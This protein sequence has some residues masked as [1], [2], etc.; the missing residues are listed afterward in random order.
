MMALPGFRCGTPPWPCRNSRRGWSSASGRNARRLSSSMSLA[1]SWNAAL[2]T[3]MSSP[4]SVWIVCSTAAGAKAG[5]ATSPLISMARRPSLL[6]RVL[7]LL[8]VLVGVEVG[9]GDVGAF[10]GEQ[11]RHGPAD[12]G[13]GAGDQ[14]R[15]AGELLGALVIGRVVHRRRRHHR[16]DAGLFLVLGGE[17]RLRIAPRAGLHGAGLAGGLERALLLGA[18]DLALDR[19][20][21]VDGARRRPGLVVRS[22]RRPCHR[23]LQRVGESKSAARRPVP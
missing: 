8:G 18:L 7:G 19:A 10:A 14:R 21:L 1:C 4:P 22:R 17:R 13:V 12:A 23:S 6:D 2:L 15:L 9:D 16:L 5:S 3:R 11:H 20:L